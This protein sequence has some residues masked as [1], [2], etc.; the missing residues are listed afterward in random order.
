M[1]RSNRSQMGD[2]VTE[3]PSWLVPAILVGITL[4]ISGG[5]LYWYFGPSVGDLIGHTPNASIKTRP[6][7]LSVSGVSFRIPE[8]YTQFPRARKGGA[9]DSVALHALLPRL[10]PFSASN[11]RSFHNNGP[12]SRVVHFQIEAFRSP[13]EEVERLER[14]YMPRVVDTLGKPVRAGLIRYEFADDR[15]RF[16]NEDLFVGKLEGGGK[17]VILCVKETEE[18][19]NPNCRRDFEFGSQLSLSYRFKRSHLEDWR[20]INGSILELINQFEA[21]AL[22]AAPI[23]TQAE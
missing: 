16:K 3:R 18:V 6:I 10:E 1:N 15:G 9:R 8:N 2:D 20:E 4:I 12:E 5:Y 11:A 23:S 17:A 19:D 22:A 14:I 7:D 13:L 21:D